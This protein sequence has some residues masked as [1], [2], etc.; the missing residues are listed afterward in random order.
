MLIKH[1]RI[2][3]ETADDILNRIN[4]IHTHN[5]F[6]AEKSTQFLYFFPGLLAL[7]NTTFLYHRNGDR[8]GTYLYA[9]LMP[10]DDTCF[11]IN[12]AAIQHRTCTI[13][14]IACIMFG[15]KTKNVIASQ[16]SIHALYNLLREQIPVAYIG[17]G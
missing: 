10:A 4:T 15:L 6:L 3:L 16:A 12:R 17:P 5:D 1:L 14:K 11:K 9:M 7:Y 8:I 2:S 13:K